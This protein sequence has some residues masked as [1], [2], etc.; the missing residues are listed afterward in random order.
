MYKNKNILSYVLGLY[1]VLLSIL[2]ATQSLLN[3]LPYTLAL[4]VAVSATLLT[5]V[6]LLYLLYVIVVYKFKS[7]FLESL[8]FKFNIHSVP[9][10]FL[11]YLA[12]LLVS[13]N[14][15]TFLQGLG[16]SSPNLESTNLDIPYIV[17]MINLFGALFIAPVMEE[18]IFRGFI[19]NALSEKFGD[20]VG[21][22]MT[23]L[24]FGLA[25]LC[26]SGDLIA[27]SFTITC[28]VILGYLKQKSRNLGISICGHFFLNL[29]ACISS[30]T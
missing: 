5:P 20:L 29:S 17:N 2:G 27:V 1:V 14:I 18:F 25:H 19:Q 12:V 4:T 3:I 8:D 13:N 23:S 16:Y 9:L 30:M 15:I 10:G 24:M 11:G 26:Y 6:V 21:I 22:V 7:P 28:G